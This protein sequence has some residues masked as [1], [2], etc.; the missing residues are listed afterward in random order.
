MD[1][2][3]EGTVARIKALVVGEWPAA[4]AVLVLVTGYAVLV[5]VDDDAIGPLGIPLFA[6]ILV[7][8]AGEL[9]RRLWA[10]QDSTE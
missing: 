3:E 8:A 9:V 10:N 7:F 4:L 1:D 2:D 6:A 5:V